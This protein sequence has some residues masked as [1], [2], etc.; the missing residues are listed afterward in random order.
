[1]NNTMNFVENQVSSAFQTKELTTFGPEDAL[2][3]YD[4]FSIYNSILKALGS[5]LASSNLED[6]TGADVYAS[7]RRMGIEQILTLYIERQ[8]SDLN[9]FKKKAANSPGWLIRQ[10]ESELDG[11]KNGKYRDYDHAKDS[12]AI[13][14]DVVE[15]VISQFGK[16]EYPRAAKLK[17]QLIEQQSI[18]SEMT[19]KIKQC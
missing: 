2:A 17:E 10:A 3:L 12:I 5:L 18:Y 13:T 7:D 6:F 16:E 15:S 14:L 11:I 1:M 8:E 19:K 4:K 9:N